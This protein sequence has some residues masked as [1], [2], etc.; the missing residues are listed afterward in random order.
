LISGLGYTTEEET[1]RFEDPVFPLQ[2]DRDATHFRAYTYA[3]LQ[4][5]ARIVWTLGAAYDEFERAPVEVRGVSPKLGVRWNITDD[6]TLRAAAFRWVKPLL[7]SDRS[8]EPTQVAGFNQLFDDLTGDDSWRYGA[9]VDW[10]ITPSLFAGTE[11]TWRSI[12]VPLQ[13][14]TAAVFEP[15]KEALHRAYVYWA[16]TPRISFSG[17]ATYDTFEARQGSILA[18]YLGTPLYL[19]TFSVPLQARYFDPS[20]FFAGLSVT[21]VEQEVLRSDF[22]KLPLQMG[23]LGLT[24]GS[25]TFSVVDLVLGWRLPRRTGIASVSVNNL[26]DETFRYQDDSFREFRDEPATGPYTPGISIM[27]RVTLDLT[28]LPQ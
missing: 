7:S 6:L 28:A 22:A 15:W 4:F 9:G 26:L 12:D 16:A 13:S 25:D 8:L 27:G 20:G 1:L 5:P 19:Q 17:E 10:R 2:F 24:D 23:G 11:L 18:T 14:G 3:N 21:Y